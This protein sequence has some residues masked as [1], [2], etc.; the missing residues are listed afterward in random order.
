MEFSLKQPKH[1][2]LLTIGL[3]TYNRAKCIERQLNDIIKQSSNLTNIIEILISDNASTDDS[4]RTIEKI[5]KTATNIKYYRQEKNIGMA[6]NFSFL[7]NK[8][9]G[10]YYWCIGDDDILRPGTIGFVVKILESYTKLG[11]IILR[12]GGVMFHL[13]NWIIW[14]PF[15]FKVN[16]AS[17]INYSPENYAKYPTCIGDSDW[18]F[19]TKS[20][21]KRSALL[22]V[23]RQKEFNSNDAL[24]LFITSNAVKDAPFYYA[25]DTGFITSAVSNT[26]TWHH[27]AHEICH[28][29]IAGVKNLSLLGFTKEEQNNLMQAEEKHVYYVNII[30][31]CEKNFSLTECL[32]HTLALQREML[33]PP[34]RERILEKLMEIDT[35]RTIFLKKTILDIAYHGDKPSTYFLKR[36]ECLQ[37][38]YIPSK[39]QEIKWLI[40]Y[41]MVIR[42]I[43][44][45]RNL[46]KR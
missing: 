37:N 30:G 46:I 45:I 10:K 3:P 5:A 1:H 21:I 28:N 44:K 26:Y 34:S 35:T 20:I 4:Y 6:A 19:I 40:K 23:I 15:K 13:N 31:C 33:I 11:A 36:Q 42:T 16:K 8:A 32:E 38:N 24:P 22:A 27:K 12:S 18:M 2:P 43:I 29:I 25:N 7:A 9:S 17:I 39:K 41:L 14:K